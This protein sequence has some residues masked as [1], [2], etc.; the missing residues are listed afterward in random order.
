MLPRNIVT[1]KQSRRLK[2][3]TKMKRIKQEIKKNSQDLIESSLPEIS[4]LDNIQIKPKKTKN[5]P[6]LLAPLGAACACIALV[7]ILIPTLLKGNTGVVVPSSSNS[8]YS[9]RSTYSY[10]SDYS[11]TSSGGGRTSSIPD[12]RP[13]IY[14]FKLD[15]YQPTF[16]TFNEVAYYSYVAYNNGGNTAPN[17]ALR[18]RKPLEASINRSEDGEEPYEDSYGRTHYPIPL[19]NPIYFSDFLYFEF[20]AEGSD[21]LTERVGNGH[22][23]AL[24]IT[25]DTFTE[26]SMLVLKNGDAYYSC[27]TNGWGTS[28]GGSGQAYYQFSS[29]KTF[30]GFEIV[31]DFNNKREVLCYFDSPDKESLTTINVEGKA[32]NI[33]PESIYYDNVTVVSTIGEIRQLFGL[34]PEFEVINNYGGP[35]QLV[36]DATVPETANFTLD[37]FEGTFRVNEDKLYLDENELIELN[38]AT[39]I[40]AAEINK[41]SHRDLVFE[42][43]VESERMFNI[44]D[45]FHNKYLYQKPVSEIGRYDYCLGMRDNR[46]VVYLIDNGE[47][48]DYGYLGYHF[49]NDGINVAWQNLFEL[50]HLELKGIFEADGVTPVPSLNDC[51]QFNINTPYIVEIELVRFFWIENDF[52]YPSMSHEIV[53]HAPTALPNANPDL[54]LL[55]VEN[56]V[57]RY[58]IQFSESGQSTF[59]FRFYRYTCQFKAVVNE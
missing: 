32:F 12:N 11:S 25:I 5:F 28:Y 39:K 29:H 21:F 23:K 55:S 38:G 1:F 26:E 7:A 10:N 15:G 49:D 36:Y 51:Y 31:K 58:Q 17:Y 8:N 14:D 53:L 41:D 48:L 42:S 22:I 52:A 47:L 56:G 34:N 6:I 24:I 13:H 37:E 44:Y 19:Y 3:S 35:D 46:L 9:R 2:E 50:S 18:Q 45:V 4:S 16:N 20:D 54:N 57:Y 59:T 33:D 30:E 27:L 43:V 40:Y